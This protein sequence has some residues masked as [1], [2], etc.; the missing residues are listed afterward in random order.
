[1]STAVTSPGERTTSA[2]AG[3]TSEEHAAEYRRRGWWRDE[4]F[5]DDLHRRAREHPRRL[6]IA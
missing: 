1:M 4:T 6:A 3:A 5:L 2:G